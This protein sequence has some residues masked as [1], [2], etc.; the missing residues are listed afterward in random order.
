MFRYVGV[1]VLYLLGGVK[2]RLE[3]QSQVW[4]VGR[5]GN[6]LACGSYRWM[7]RK[8]CFMLFSSGVEVLWL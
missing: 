6:L 4:G 8:I 7:F 1:G 3:G 5:D 2:L